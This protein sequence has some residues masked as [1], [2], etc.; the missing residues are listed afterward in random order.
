ML[1]ELGISQV[2][3]AKLLE[4]TTRTVNLWVTDDGRDIPGPVK[5][6]FRVLTSLDE[7]GRK[8]EFSRLKQGESKMREGMFGIQFQ[9]AEDIGAGA[10]VFQGGTIYG[11]DVGG[12]KYDGSYTYNPDS[13]TVDVTIKITIPPNVKTVQGISNPYEWSFVVEESMPA[14]MDS[15]DLV[16]STPIGKVHATIAFM[17]SL[18]A[19]A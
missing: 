16:V 8:K 5:A 18:P 13:D 6:Y 19:A 15:H 7:T 4:V 12:A 3:L 2:D 9:G 1:L 14:N 11:V 10:L 17:R